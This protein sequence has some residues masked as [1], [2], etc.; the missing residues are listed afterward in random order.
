MHV[1]DL[2]WAIAKHYDCINS[3]HLKLIFHRT[4]M[5]LHE[6]VLKVINRTNSEYVGTACAAVAR[7]CIEVSHDIS[8]QLIELVNLL[9]SNLHLQQ[10]IMRLTPIR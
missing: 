7:G 4:K 5:M 1:S 2:F 6:E 10:F 3:T 8:P 9:V